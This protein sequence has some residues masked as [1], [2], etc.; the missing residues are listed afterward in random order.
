MDGSPL[1]GRA[2]GQPDGT[3]C[4][5]SVLVMAALL[6]S[7]GLAGRL[8]GDG[9]PAR[10]RELFAA[11]VLDLHRVLSR[12]FLR[13]RLQLPWPRALG[14]SP[15]AVA[16]EL[17]HLRGRAHHTRQAR[18]RRRAAWSRTYAALEAGSPVALLVG[19]RWR[20]AHWVLVVAARGGD[21]DVYDPAARVTNGRRTG[22]TVRLERARFLAGRCRLAGWDEPWAVVLPGPS[23]LGRLSRSGR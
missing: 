18:V 5:P 10:Q 19:S 17:T 16:G 2:T 3:T 4:G 15:W 21:V 11:T 7:P 1:P 14:T 23:P 8:V 12:P 6:D 13:G 9:D 22:A 20:P